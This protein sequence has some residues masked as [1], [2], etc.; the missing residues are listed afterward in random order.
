MPFVEQSHRDNPDLSI[1]G[2]KCYVYY[3]QMLDE[4]NLKP[5]WTTF[6][7]LASRV[8]PEDYQ[9]AY[10]LALLVFFDRYVKKYEDVKEA[11]NGGIK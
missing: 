5:S 9:R 6:D 11:L 1:P 2:D 10:F 7:R 3:K 8:F 4:W